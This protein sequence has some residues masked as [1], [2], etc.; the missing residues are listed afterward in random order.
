[1]TRLS[2][3][4]EAEIRETVKEL[5]A[6]AGAWYPLLL[7]EIDA[8]REEL[9]IEQLKNRNSLARNLW[10]CPIIVCLGRFLPF[11]QPGMGCQSNLHAQA[12]RRKLTSGIENHDPWAFNTM[13]LPVDQIPLVRGINPQDTSETVQWYL[14]YKNLEKVRK[15]G[16]P[17]KY[18][19]RLL[20]DEAIRDALVL[21][22][23]LKRAGLDEAYCLCSVPEIRFDDNGNRISRI[24]GRVLALYA[25]PRQ[26]GP[27]VFDWEWRPGNEN[28]GHPLDSENNFGR[29][30]WTRL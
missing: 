24:A 19:D 27:T 22:G 10:C 15:A 14:S 6:K 1:M 21:F 2:P 11:W 29:A 9:K 3:E 18:H 12:S 16:P 5:G 23:D 26:Y 20:L 28:T 8:L 13:P 4:R 30:I 17:S 25:E 7:A